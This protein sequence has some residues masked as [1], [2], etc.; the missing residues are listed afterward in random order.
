M[1]RYRWYILVYLVAFPFKIANSLDL[2]LY[3]IY[4]VQCGTNISILCLLLTFLL[5]DGMKSEIKEKYLELQDSS[6]VR[7][8]DNVEKFQ[9]I[10][11]LSYFFKDF[12]FSLYKYQV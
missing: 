3:Q 10:I 11:F 12:P 7:K 1:S 6:G 4:V 2:L 8:Y 9:D 5:R